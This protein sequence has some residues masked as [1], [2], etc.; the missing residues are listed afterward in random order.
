MYL[1]GFCI[2]QATAYRVFLRSSI[3]RF[4]VRD[5]M[6]HLYFIACVPHLSYL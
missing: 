1:D 3:F 6:R 4:C 5:E 2:S